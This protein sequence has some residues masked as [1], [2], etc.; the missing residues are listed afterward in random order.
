MEVDDYKNFATTTE[1]KYGFVP[2]LATVIKEDPNKRV[3]SI[4]W[5]LHEV[6]S[7]LSCR[8]FSVPREELGKEEFYFGTTT[9][10]GDRID[11]RFIFGSVSIKRMAGTSDNHD[12]EVMITLSL[13]LREDNSRLA[14]LVD[15][16][17]E[18]YLFVSDIINQCDVD[19]NNPFEGG[20]EYIP[21]VRKQVDLTYSSDFDLGKMV[22][23]GEN[24]LFGYFSIGRVLKLGKRTEL[25]TLDKNGLF[26]LSPDRISQARELLA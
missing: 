22:E 8:P 9:Q 26:V 11:P 7:T 3:E 18:T 15:K 4:D 1:K 13:Y 20:E 25:T 23:T 2:T 14:Q 6:F 10:K 21:R 24:P 17:R 5:Q 12:P 16:F 19:F